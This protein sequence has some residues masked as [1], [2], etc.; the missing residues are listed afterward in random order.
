MM[1]PI[2]VNG[3]NIKKKIPPLRNA[4]CSTSPVAYAIALAGVE[5]GK[6]SAH[7]Q[8]IAII[9]GAAIPKSPL[10]LNPKGTR[11]AEAAVLLMI[12]DSIIPTR[13]KTATIPIGK[14]GSLSNSFI[15]ISDNPTSTMASPRAK[16]PATNISVS[17]GN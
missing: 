12:F 7:E 10:K 17:Q 1:I 15:M 11:I 4:F 2:A 14:N 13:A 3:P 16:P 8:L 5:T 9:S 6:S